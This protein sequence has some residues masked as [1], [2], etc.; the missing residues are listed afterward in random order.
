M[1]GKKKAAQI[2]T[3]SDQLSCSLSC[4]YGFEDWEVIPFCLWYLTE[5]PNI[6]GSAMKIG[7]QVYIP[8][9]LD[10]TW[11]LVCTLKFSYL[12]LAKV[13]LSAFSE[14]VVLYPLF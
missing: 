13:C 6:A 5:N 3:T 1:T 4:S 8:S 12:L 10:L 9:P 11:S 2:N 7:S 14:N